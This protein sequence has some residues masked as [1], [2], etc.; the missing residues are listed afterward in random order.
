MRFKEAFLNQRSGYIGNERGETMKLKQFLTLLAYRSSL[1]LG[2]FALV[3]TYVLMQP[4]SASAWAHN[5]AFV[6]V[7]H[8]SP[9]AGNVDVFVDGDQ[10]LSNVAF[11]TVSDYIPLAA[12]S[13]RIQVAP[14]GKGSTAA[15]I[16]ET[17]SLNAGVAYTVAALGTPSSGFWLK[18]F[19]DT[20]LVRDGQARV[21]VY[22]LSPNTGPVDIAVGGR[23]VIKDLTYLNAS[24]YLTVAPGSY[25]F[26]VTA[27]RA[28]VTVPIS[29][30]LKAERIN[31]VFALGLFNGRPSLRF[32]LA[33]I[34]GDED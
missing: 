12:G 10:Q 18:A 14:V 34:E 20:Y 27:T 25:T 23:T 33:S 13:H 8:A 17:L 2:V 16:T 15:V 3:L 30:Q 5:K 28:R 7:V 24:D 31:S 21:R 19:V 22:H 4:A 26:R 32:V 1:L 9:A 6:R 11:G 29:A